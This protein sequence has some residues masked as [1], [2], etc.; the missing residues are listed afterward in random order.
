[1]SPYEL[2]YDYAMYTNQPIFLTGKAG[3][4]KTTFLRKLLGECP[5]MS[6]VVAPTGVAAINAQGVTIHSFFQLPPQ[7]FLPTDQSRRQLFAEMQM[8]GAK[9]RVIRNLELLVID[10]VSMVRADLLDAIDAVLRHIKHRPNLPFG[11][12]QVIFIG[13]LYQLSPVAREDDWQILRSYYSGPYFFQALVFQQIQPIYIELDHV[14]R[15]TNQQFVD[16]LNQV[17][18]NQVTPESLALLNARYCPPSQLKQAKQA[19]L[20]STH[21]H[22]VD[23]INLERLA[24]LSTKVCSFDAEIQDNFPESMYPMAERLILKKGARVMFNRNDSSPE[25]L[26]YNG[27]LGEVIALSDQ[28]IQVRC[29]DGV[30]LQ[31]HRE[32]WENVRYISSEKSD[33]IQTEVIGTFSHFPL[34]LAWAVT[35]HKAQGLTFDQVVIDAED[36]FAAG[37]VYVALSRCRSLEGITLLSPIPTSA[38][39]NARDVL[40]FVQQQPTIEQANEHYPIAERNYLAIV[41]S[42]LYD[43]RDVLHKWEML[44]RVVSATTSFNQPATTEF[45]QEIQGTL[46]MWQR[47]VEKFQ[48]QIRLLAIQP[49]AHNQLAERL[50]AASAYFIPLIKTILA[51]LKESPAYTDDKEDAQSYREQIEEIYVDLDRKCYLMDKTIC[52]PLVQ[53]YFG[54]RKTYSIP[55]IRILASADTAKNTMNVSQNPLLFI[56]LTMLRKVVAQ[57][58]RTAPYL[59]ISTKL[60]VDISNRMPLSKKDLMRTPGF[61]PKKYA[62]LGDQILAI[63]KQYC[64]GKGLHSE[65]L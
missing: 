17:R 58:Q 2:A 20:L 57:E 18:Q 14:F 65:L 56:R 48:N 15:Q 62:L 6:A 38:L 40:Q 4:G 11:G 64:K 10:E 49:T 29:D 63:T 28:T 22:K 16:I 37:Q 52:T 21:N 30:E 25:K 23:Q 55:R 9:Q 8:R 39:T 59:I 31:V 44:Q 13:D 60:L 34:R 61:G 33:A 36:A 53:T 7:I 1:M 32:K 42:N 46:L 43:F 50:Q 45:L 12:V 19:I 26:Y 5:K 47:T 27:K 24:E 3:T 54:A 51:K 35:I 41:L